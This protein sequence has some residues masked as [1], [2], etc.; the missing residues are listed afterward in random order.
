MKLAQQCLSS[1][2]IHILQ[3]A[4]LIELSLEENNMIR[5]IPILIVIVCISACKKEN[6]VEPEPTMNYVDLH[7]AEVKDGVFQRVDLDDNHTQDFTFTTRLVNDPALNQSTLEFIVIARIDAYLMLVT[8]T[9]T[10]KKFVK[11]DSLR[12]AAASGSSWTAFSLMILAKK[13]TPQTGASFWEGEWKDASHHYLPV[14]VTKTNGSVHIGWIEL[15]MD[16]AG[17]KLILHKAA[18]SIDAEK[19]VAAG[20]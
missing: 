4:N 10:G 15:S 8:G 20:I 12:V 2:C 13:I 19:N 7:Q 14:K 1:L 17:E 11:G 16:S 6:T 18:L 3:K 9:Q 5:L